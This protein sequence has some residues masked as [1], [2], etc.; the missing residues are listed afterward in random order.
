LIGAISPLGNLNKQEIY[1]FAKWIN[2]TY[3]NVIPQEIITRP[4][5][6][7]LSDNQVDPFDYNLLS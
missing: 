7:E 6:A 1:E 3:N 4:A 2:K 5:S